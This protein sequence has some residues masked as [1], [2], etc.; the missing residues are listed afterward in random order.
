MV[1]HANTVFGGQ[2]RSLWEMHEGRRPSRV[3]SL[4]HIAERYF[5]YFSMYRGVVSN[6]VE[7]PATVLDDVR[8]VQP[9]FMLAVPRIWEK[10]YS[11]VDMRLKEG[12]RLRRW[13]LVVRWR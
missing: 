8:E 1:S 12:T 13:A 11:Q 6:F 4:C 5:T 9:E 7:S 10:L 2:Q 3:P